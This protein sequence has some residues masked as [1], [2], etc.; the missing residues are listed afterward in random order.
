M[1]EHEARRM[2]GTPIA[3][4]LRAWLVIEVLFSVGAILTIA[5]DPVNTRDRFAWN[6]EPLVMAAVLGAYY[7]S[8]GLVTLLPVFA[9]RWEMIR[10]MILPTVLFTSMELLT[11]FLHWSAFSLGTPGFIVWLLSYLLPPPILLGFY[12]W[13]ERHAREATRAIPQDPL[14]PDVRRTLLHVGGLTTLLSILI[15][16]LPQAFIAFAPWQVTPL[17]ARVFAGFLLAAGALML[18]MT[19]ENDRSRV[20]VGVPLLILM[21]PAVTLQ[22][23]R[24]PDQVNFA[25]TALF[26]IYGIMLVA[27][28]LGVYLAR[29]NWRRVFQ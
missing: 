10:V 28:A 4:P 16:I 7:I 14:S 26:L 17:S 5:L 21:F 18:S 29:R 24:F 20:L 6:V 2:T 27:F 22:I 11:T 1:R 12:L 23:A 9:R 25:N 13:H 15:F 8:A 3:W 19:R